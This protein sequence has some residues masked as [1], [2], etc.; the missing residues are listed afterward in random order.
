MKPTLDILELQIQSKKKG[1]GVF[2]SNFE[3]YTRYSWIADKKQKKK[4]KNV[5]SVFKL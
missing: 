1:F 2:I 5:L 3:A 4:E